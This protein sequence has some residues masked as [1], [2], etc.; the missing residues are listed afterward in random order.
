MLPAEQNVDDCARQNELEMDALGVEAQFRRPARMSICGIS[1]R[2]IE[3]PLWAR[4]HRKRAGIP[5]SVFK[6]GTCQSGYGRRKGLGSNRT[7]AAISILALS[8]CPPTA[9]LQARPTN[10][11][12]P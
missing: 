2:P 3:R 11:K 6:R 4:S 7:R 5:P 9:W 8:K 10:R 1:V 12:C